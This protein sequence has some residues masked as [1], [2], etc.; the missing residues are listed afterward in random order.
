MARTTHLRKR[1]EYEDKTTGRSAKPKWTALLFDLI[2]PVKNSDDELVVLD[3]VRV[4]RD[5]FTDEMIDCAVGHGFM[6][7][8]GDDMAGI[9]KKAL[10]DG[11]AF[12]AKTGFSDYIA[13]RI[14][15]MLENFGANVW[16][17]EGEGATGGSNITI[18][19]QAIFATFAAAKQELD[20]EAKAKVMVRLQDEDYRKKAKLRPDIAS[21][22]ARITAE[23][24]AERAEA[25]AKK[26]KGT[27]AADLKDLLA[28]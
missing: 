18:L 4:E 13:D 26:A 2:S 1:Y 28:I 16:V 9:D 20:D 6:Q 27:T 11:I 25:A 19:S 3:T 7:K 17:A 15:D 12:D 5:D 14:A 21:H 24:A 10:T 8:I 23:R 22:V